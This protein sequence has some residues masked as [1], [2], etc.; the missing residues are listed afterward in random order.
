MSEQTYLV[1]TPEQDKE[2]ALAIATYAIENLRTPV[3][4]ASYKTSD[5]EIQKY[6]P[7]MKPD[8][9]N[10]WC[11]KVGKRKGIDGYRVKLSEIER[12]YHQAEQKKKN[13]K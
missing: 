7:L 10:R 8:T 3:K 1:R 2:Y 4:E 12:L 5:P 11:K 9:L 6:Y 13:K